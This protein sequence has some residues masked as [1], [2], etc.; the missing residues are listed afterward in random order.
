MGLAFSSSR[1]MYMTM[2]HMNCRI[3]DRVFLDASSS[4]ALDKLSDAASNR[5][6]N[7]D[8]YA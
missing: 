1:R 7:A 3:D 6:S 5:N 4:I 2:S 8:L